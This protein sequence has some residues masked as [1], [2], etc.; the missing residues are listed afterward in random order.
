MQTLTTY[1]YLPTQNHVHEV[2]TLPIPLFGP[3][4]V[5]IKHPIN[6]EFIDTFTYLKTMYLLENNQFYQ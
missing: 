6:L 2:Q 1:T 4:Q 5:I 3:F